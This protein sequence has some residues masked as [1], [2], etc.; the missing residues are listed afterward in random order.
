MAPSIWLEGSR[1][2]LHLQEICS[3]RRASYIQLGL[4]LYVGNSLRNARADILVRET[5]S[6]HSALGMVY[7]KARWDPGRQ[8]STTVPGYTDVSRIPKA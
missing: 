1:R 7:A 6:I 2:S 4:S 5:H 8:A 3:H